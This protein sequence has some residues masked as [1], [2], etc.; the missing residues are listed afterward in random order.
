M[1][2]SAFQKIRFHY[3]AKPFYFPHRTALKSFLLSQL[4]EEGRQVDA[5]NYIFCDDAYLHQINQAYLKHDSYTDIITFEL[6]EKDQPL[7]SDIYISLERIKEN[8]SS[9]SISSLIEL[10]RVIFHGALHLCGYK[11]K[12]HAQ[13]KVMRERENLWLSLF[14]VSRGK[15]DR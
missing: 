11:D 4:E 15:N 7:L 9:F 5:L 6:S 3:L 12:S 13:K 8:A 14:I 1:N 10:H 2:N